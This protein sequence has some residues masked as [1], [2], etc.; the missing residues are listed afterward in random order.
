MKGLL[1]SLPEQD[2]QNLQQTEQPEWVGPMLA[3]VTERRFPIP[4]GF[5]NAFWLGERCLV[6]KK[7]SHVRPMSRNRKQMS[8]AYPELVAEVG[9]SEW[10]R[11]GKLRHPRFLGL[12]RDKQPRRVSRKH[13]NHERKR[14]SDRIAD[15]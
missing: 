2:R 4:I 14:N 1:N 7:D 5:S 6:H 8:A 3:T 15:H 13:S 11:D 9:F 10:T 12:W